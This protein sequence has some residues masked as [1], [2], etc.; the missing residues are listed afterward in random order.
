M[1]K[2]NT[3]GMALIVLIGIF[4]FVTSCEGPEGPV[5]PAGPA[6]AQGPAGANGTQGPP[7]PTGNANVIASDW[8]TNVW[9]VQSNGA[10]THTNI[11]APEITQAILDK[12]SLFIYFKTSSTGSSVKLIPNPL[13]SGTTGAIVYIIDGFF[14]IGTFGVFTSPPAVG[15][16]GIEVSFPN[17]QVRYVIIPPASTGRVRLPENPEDYYATCA[18]LGIEP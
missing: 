13:Y 9:T 7:G 10:R 2:H 8:I 14:Q 1:K 18:W 6:G 5:G 16:N 4:S 15:S 12:A 11:P 17:S 3:Y